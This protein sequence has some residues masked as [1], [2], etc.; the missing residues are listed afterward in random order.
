LLILNN[1]ITTN[2]WTF[3]NKKHA[4]HVKLKKHLNKDKIFGIGFLWD[5]TKCSTA[6]DVVKDSGP[7]IGSFQMV[8]L[9][10]MSVI[11]FI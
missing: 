6:N 3:I 11:T 5:G 4:E 7:R 10:A 9:S 1:L 2:S 8:R